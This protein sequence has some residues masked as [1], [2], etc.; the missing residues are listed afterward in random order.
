MVREV[1]EFGLRVLEAVRSREGQHFVVQGKIYRPAGFVWA[2][3][4]LRG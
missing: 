1:R 2:A 4:R 3:P